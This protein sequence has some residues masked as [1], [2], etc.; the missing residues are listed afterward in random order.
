MLYNVCPILSFPPLWHVFNEL[1]S[2]RSIYFSIVYAHTG[3]PKELF[4]KTDN[5]H[6]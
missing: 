3:E 6:V 1:Y 2:W 4:V 5:L